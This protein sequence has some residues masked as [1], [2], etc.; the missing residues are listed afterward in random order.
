[1]LSGK[2]V[3][4]KILNKLKSLP[5][6]GKKNVLEYI[7]NLK[8]KKTERTLRLLKKTSGAWKGLVDAEKLKSDIYSDRL[9]STR[10]RVNF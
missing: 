6:E 1:M 10:S 5:E 8:T 7:D 2:A 4:D 9:I 3:E